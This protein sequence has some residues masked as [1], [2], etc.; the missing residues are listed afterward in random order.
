MSINES[1]THTTQTKRSTT[2][3]QPYKDEQILEQLYIEDGHTQAEI[4]N[5]YGID[6]S[7]VHYWLDKH[8]IEREEPDVYRSES[9]K[10]R[11]QYTIPEEETHFYQYQL[12]AL[13]DYGV[14]DV[15]D[16]FT[17]VHHLMASPYA[18]DLPANLRVMNRREHVKSHAEGTAVDPPSKILQFYF[19]DDVEDY[20]H[21]GSKEERVEDWE[22]LKEE[23]GIDDDQGGDSQ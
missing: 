9:D 12:N 2:E 3:L 17:H 20:A 23:H 8:G 10:G 7:T 11:I 13:L 14:D 1:H 18:V 4:A 22:R 19:E 5:F 21:F 16:P 15:F 6:Q